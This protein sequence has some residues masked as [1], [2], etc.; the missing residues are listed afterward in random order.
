MASIFE[1]VMAEV[2]ASFQIVRAERLR[3]NADVPWLVG[4]KALQ[5]HKQPR[6][7]AW[8]RGG[9]AFDSPIAIGPLR[10]DNTLVTPLYAANEIVSFVACGSSDQDTEELWFDAVAAVRASFGA[11]KLQP[12]SFRW[13]TQEEEQAGWLNAEREVVIQE[14]TFPLIVPKT[15]EY[16]VTVTSQEEECLLVPNDE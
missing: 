16:L 5:T 10:V 4:R 12:A 3:Q 11:T 8:I 9:G 15:I 6:Y 1:T 2:L 7:V 14:F 13:T